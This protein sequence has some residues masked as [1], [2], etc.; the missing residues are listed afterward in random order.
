MRILFQ[1]V[2]AM[3]IKEPESYI[4]K[5]VTGQL[6][7]LLIFKNINYTSISLEKSPIQYNMV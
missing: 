6:N 3:K 7:F 5:H 4:L 1:L 2:K